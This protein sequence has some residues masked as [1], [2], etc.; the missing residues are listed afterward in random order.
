MSFIASNS[1]QL[2]TPKF[3]SLFLP[4]FQVQSR[5]RCL[6]T[7]V[8]EVLCS[9]RC[10]DRLLSVDGQSLEKVEH[11]KAVSMLKQTGTKVVLE[12][13]SWLGTEI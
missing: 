7:I 8:D 3:Y 10:G 9:D 4:K 6:F 13:V 11:A 1:W 2:K 5:Q 12:I